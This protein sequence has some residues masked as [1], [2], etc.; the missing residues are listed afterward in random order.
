GGV[1]AQFVLGDVPDDR[2]VRAGGARRRGAGQD[3]ERATVPA[4]SQERNATLNYRSVLARELT[5]EDAWLYRKPSRHRR[6]PGS[7]TGGGAADS[8]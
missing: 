7:T 2:D 4:R 3:R 5:V 1:S 8:V 6:S